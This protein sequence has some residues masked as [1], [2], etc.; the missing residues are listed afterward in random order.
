MYFLTRL[1]LAMVLPTA[2]AVVRLCCMILCVAV[3]K[4]GFLEKEGW[5]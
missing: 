2:K 5:E 4:E 1:K 3:V